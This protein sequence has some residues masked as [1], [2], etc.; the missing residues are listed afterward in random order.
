MSS[1]STSRASV[2]SKQYT[3]RKLKIG[4]SEQMDNLAHAAGTLY[5]QVVLSYWRTVRHKGLW[6][7]AKHLMR[8]HTSPLLHAHSADALVQSFFGALDS[9]RARRKA[10]PAAKPPHTRKRFYRVQWKT[11][12]IR[13]TGGLLYLANGRG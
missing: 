13:L 9:W 7:K 10:D 12:A 5:S 4:R 11:S 2:V 3:V 1:R 6:L 8:W